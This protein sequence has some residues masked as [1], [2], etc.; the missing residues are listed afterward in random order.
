MR[1]IKEFILLFCEP[2]THIINLSIQH[3]IVPDEMKIARVIPIFKSDDQSLLTNYRLISVLPSFSKFLERGIDIL[4]SKHYGFRK[5]H[6][7][8]LALIDLHDKISTAFEQV[9]FPLVFFLTSQNLRHCKS[10]HSF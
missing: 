9:N 7:T 10:C 1:V 2:L 3:D 5:N 4:F 8:A 6:S